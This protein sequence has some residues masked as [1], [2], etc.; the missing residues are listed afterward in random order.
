MIM[1]TVAAFLCWTGPGGTAWGQAYRNGYVTAAKRAQLRRTI[2]IPGIDSIRVSGNV[3][4]ELGAGESVKIVNNNGNEQN[5]LNGN[6][7]TSLHLG[8]DTSKNIVI[9]SYT[10]GGF[11]MGWI[12]FALDMSHSGND[13]VT[14]AAD[15]T[16]EGYNNNAL[17]A[18]GENQQPAYF[19]GIAK[20]EDCR[21]M[22]NFPGWMK[23]AYNL[24]KADY[25]NGFTTNNSQGVWG[26]VRTN[27]P[28]LS[29]YYDRPVGI[30]RH[31]GKRVFSFSRY[32]KDKFEVNK[33]L[34]PNYNPNP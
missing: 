15:S 22:P 34:G 26:L 27:I 5:D 25:D 3:G 17:Y 20:F 23:A 32:T 6:D 1:A 12:S 29:D 28:N 8:S 19:I 10:G 14:S 13:R 18:Y 16:G 21:Y 33:T 4:G 11:A 24:V 30:A 9:R 31:S 7:A 2:H